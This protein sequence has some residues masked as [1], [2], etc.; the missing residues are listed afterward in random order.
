MLELLVVL[1]IMTILLSIV[2]ISFSR[3]NRNTQ[4]KVS[5]SQVQLVQLALEEYRAQCRVYPSSLDLDTNNNYPGSF[6]NQCLVEFGQIVSPEIMDEL[7]NFEYTALESSS[8]IPD[9]CSAYHLSIQINQPSRFLD[10]D[11]D[12]EGAAEWV[13]C[14]TSGNHVEYTDADG[15]YDITEGVRETA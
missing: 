15:W 12:F 6:N 1:F 13:G 9:A 4:N 11:A 10:E 5:V 8:S 14:G 2:L 7:E 3:G